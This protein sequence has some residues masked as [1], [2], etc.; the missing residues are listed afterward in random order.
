MTSE[1]PF[2]APAGC[3]ILE[4]DSEFFGRRIARVEAS[5]LS[6]GGEDAV[7]RWCACERVECVY[8]LVDADDQSAIDVAQSRGFRLVDLRVTLEVN[9][10]PA[11]IA[12]GTLE[13]RVRVASE[14]DVD[15]LAAIARESHRSSRFYADDHFDRRRCD[16]LYEVWITKSCR[17]WADRVFVAELAG[18]PVGYLTCH[19]RTDEGQIGL[20]GVHA[21]CRARGA[22]AALIAEARR[23]FAVQG[24]SRVSVVTQGR[25]TA[26]LRF[27]QKAGFTV[28][29]IQFWYH[30]WF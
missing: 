6:S 23:W 11:P 10:S 8:L 7:E 1:T 30:K 28:R 3:R 22:G 19:R 12:A 24:M 21:A 9:G 17:G 5:A 18:A 27:Y 2:P 14:T 13:V 25:N 26:A 16:E 20:V 29:L 15:E 4:W